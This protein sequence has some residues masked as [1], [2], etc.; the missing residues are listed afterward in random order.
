M[1]A[2]RITKEENDPIC[3]RAS[4]GGKAEEGFY[5]TYRGDRQAI[6]TMLRTVVSA[7]EK[8]QTVPELKAGEVIRRQRFG[9]S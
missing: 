4:I 8:Y 5:I 6:L 3:L 2:I 1:S 7:F 9:S